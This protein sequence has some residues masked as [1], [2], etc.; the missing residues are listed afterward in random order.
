MTKITSGK[1]H[2]FDREKVFISNDAG[3]T[4]KHIS[5]VI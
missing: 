4:R 5:S 1:S 2:M 3:L